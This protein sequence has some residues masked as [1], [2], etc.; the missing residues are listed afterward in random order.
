MKVFKSYISLS[1][2]VTIL[3]CIPSFIFAKAQEKIEKT[4]T[5]DRD[6]KV[7]LKN[8]S[9]D[10]VV[11]SWHKHE[12]KIIALKVA[13]RER[14]LDDVTVDIHQTNGNIRIITSYHKPFSLFRKHVPVYYELLIPDK[15]HFRLK[16]VS[17]SAQ[18]R[19][20]GGFLDIK[21]TSGDIKIIKAYNGVKCKTISGEIEIETAKKS[22]K[23]KTIS[24]D[25][26]L[27]DITGD[28]DLETTS[29]K[30]A[31]R[32]IKGSFEVETVSG[33]IEVEAFSHA[34]EIG[35]ETISGRIKLQGEL[36][37]E[38]IY[39]VDSFSGKTKIILPSASN[40][41]LRTKT[42]SGDI[43]CDFELAISDKIDRKNFQGIVGKGGARLIISS[44]SGDIRISKR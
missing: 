18:A 24:G 4:Y 34:E 11:K 31:V 2:L 19:E 7:Y 13:R 35:V 17:G 40:F 12:V 28:V 14:N 44:F 41:E 32:T 29:G 30:I 9:G 23:C 5:L 43:K 8:I 38:G 15:A 1:L 3:F 36:S 6:G 26:Y 27:E 22:V 33:R 25:I 42:F 21:T 16:T 20:I 39:E 37:P 10:I